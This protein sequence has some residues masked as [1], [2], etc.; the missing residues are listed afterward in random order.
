[1]VDAVL[2][3]SQRAKDSLPQRLERCAL[4][5]LNQPF[6]KD[7]LSRVW[8]ACQWRGCAD[9]GANRL[10][11]VLQ[12]SSDLKSADFL[13]DLVKGDLDSL[14]S[15]VNEYY[16]GL[17][18][19]V[20]KDEDQYATDLMKCIAEVQKIEA[21]SPGQSQFTIILLGGLSGRL[22]QTIHTM[23]Y[24]H[25]LRKQRKQ[26]FVVTDD[27]VGWV[28]DEGEHLIEVDLSSIGPTCGLLPVG[29]ESSILTT[30]G[31]RWNLDNFESSFNGLVSSSN[32]TVSEEVYISTSR[33]IFWCIELAK[34]QP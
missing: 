17:G 15:D 27:N 4:I 26:I 34:S 9:G 33:P 29:V 25:K 6:S 31:L 10:F 8:A 20:V 23:S 13:P 24:L 18:V 3:R 28:L 19:P 7:L 22:D 21:S 11:D 5:I 2:A 12:E 32:A 16:A 30:R 14:R 1:M